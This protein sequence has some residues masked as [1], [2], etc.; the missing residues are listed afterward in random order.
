MPQKATVPITLA[1]HITIVMTEAANRGITDAAALAR[2]RQE[3]IDK[4]QSRI[5][6]Q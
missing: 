1:A 5:Q 6:W 2:I 4:W 3:A